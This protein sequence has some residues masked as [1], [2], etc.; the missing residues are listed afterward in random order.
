MKSIILHILSTSC[1]SSKDYDSEQ[2]NNS[3]PKIFD[4]TWKIEKNARMIVEEFFSFPDKY[5]AKSWKT[6]AWEMMYM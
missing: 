3:L 2:E 5:F 6:N 1:L 4:E